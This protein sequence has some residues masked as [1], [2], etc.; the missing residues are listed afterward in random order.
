MTANIRRVG[1]AIDCVDAEPVARFHEQLPPIRAI[2][3][4]LTVTPI[5][6]RGAHTWSAAGHTEEYDNGPT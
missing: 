5:A 4:V 1:L 3:R 2:P 6:G